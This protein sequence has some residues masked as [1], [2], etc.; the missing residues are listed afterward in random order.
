MNKTIEIEV[1]NVYGVPMIYPVC[2]TA[3]L[4]ADLVGKKTFTKT[5]L[6]MIQMLGFDVK[7]AAQKPFVLN[8]NEIC[9]A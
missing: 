2:A 1:R 6:N 7:Q 5:D 8:I 4:F 9:A 3:K